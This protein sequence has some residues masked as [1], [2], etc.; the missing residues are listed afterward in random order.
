[1]KTEDILK[2]I[3]TSINQGLQGQV[4]GVQVN[5]SDGAPG[6]GISLTIRGANSFTGS[7]PLYVID[8]IPFT[9]PTPTGSSVGGAN[10]SGGAGQVDQ[11]LV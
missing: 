3:P 10:P 11:R 1:M 8:G 7:E 4:A 6:A 2:T 5:R 9:S